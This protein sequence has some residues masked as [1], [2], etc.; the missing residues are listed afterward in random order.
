[1]K[2]PESP[3]ALL[4]HI[5]SMDH[6]ERICF[7]LSKEARKELG[8]NAY[9]LEIYITFPF[10]NTK[11]ADNDPFRVLFQY[12]TVNGKVNGLSKMSTKRPFIKLSLLKK[13][14]DQMA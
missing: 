11:L 8:K 5:K 9:N 13:L 2:K 1:M 10:E 6:R 7:E 12:V 3:E 4:S 14:I